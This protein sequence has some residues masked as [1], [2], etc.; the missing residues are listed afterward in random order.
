MPFDDLSDLYVKKC[1]MYSMNI[2][3]TID[4]VFMVELSVQE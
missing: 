2:H 4:N 1:H 3:V